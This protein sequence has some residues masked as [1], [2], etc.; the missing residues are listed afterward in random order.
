MIFDRANSIRSIL[1]SLNGSHGGTVCL[2]GLAVAVLVLP[3]ANNVVKLC[4][5][6]FSLSLFL[7]VFL[8]F[9]FTRKVGCGREWQSSGAGLPPQECGLSQISMPPPSPPL[10]HSKRLIV[11]DTKR[12]RLHIYIYLYIYTFNPFVHSF[13][14]LATLEAMFLKAMDDPD[15]RLNRTPLRE[16]RGSLQTSISHWTRFSARP[17]PWTQRSRKLSCCS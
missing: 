17:S 5:F 7:L 8:F 1:K 14:S 13:N 10:C 4:R 16:R 2:S 15:I 12:E 9:Y 3:S 11:G 6:F